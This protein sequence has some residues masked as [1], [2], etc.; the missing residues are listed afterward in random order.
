VVHGTLQFQSKGATTKDFKLGL[1]L[2][3]PICAKVWIIW[4]ISLLDLNAITKKIP[5]KYYNFQLQSCL[6]SFY[7]HISSQNFMRDIDVP[8]NIMAL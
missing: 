7:K 3:R 2:I 5:K 1:A 8:Q 4:I 6:M